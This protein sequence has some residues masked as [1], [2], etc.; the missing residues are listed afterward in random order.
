[1]KNARRGF[2]SSFA[3]HPS[4][5]ILTNTISITSGGQKSLSGSPVVP[6]P[7][8]TTSQVGPTRLIPEHKA[9]GSVS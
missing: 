1:M 5:F 7:R 6:R 3:L 9:R 2:F 4:A 8:L